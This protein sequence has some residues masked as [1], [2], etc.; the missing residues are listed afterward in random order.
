M[1]KITSLF[2]SMSRFP[3]IRDTCY[4][5][6]QYI[7]VPIPLSIQCLNFLREK[8]IIFMYVSD[9]SVIHSDNF[10]SSPCK[11]AFVLKGIV[12]YKEFLENF[13]FETL[14]KTLSL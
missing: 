3:L 4:S 11:T 10:S 7:N 6:L 5:Q 14:F 2:L 9:N 1:S 8:K 12:K 13:Y